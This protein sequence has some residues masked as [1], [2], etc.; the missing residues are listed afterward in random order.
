VPVQAA[1][2]HI[3]IQLGRD[4]GCPKCPSIRCVIDTAAALTTGNFHFFAQ[5]AKAFPHT[6]SAIYSN[7]DYSPIILSGIVQQDGA[8]VSTDLNVAFQFT[9]PY[10]TCEG[11]A[12]SLLVA[13]GP[14]VTVNTILGLPFIQQ[15][16]MTIDASDHVADLRALDTP[17]FPIDFRRAMCT[18]PAVPADVTQGPASSNTA[19]V[20]QEITRLEAFFAGNAAP[21]KPEGILL[22]N[23]RLRKVG[24]A[25]EPTSP[26]S[27]YSDSS[28]IVSPGSG[29][30]PDFA[31]EADG[32][33]LCDVSPFSA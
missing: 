15:T 30:E 19:R 6:V 29:I 5:I 23:K 9:M 26:A 17:P 25:A 7:T 27:S 24:F 18:I 11:H 13:T 3:T 31:S 2:P 10:L 4:L 14:N 22:P 16:R 1:F 33:D 21:T 8:S 12:T 20:L 28:T 32:S